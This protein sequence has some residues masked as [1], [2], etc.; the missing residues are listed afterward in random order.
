MHALFQQIPWR[1]SECHKGLSKKLQV[2]KGED[3][4]KYKADY[5]KYEMV[6]INSEKQNY[7]IKREMVW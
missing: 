4:S 5:E 7:V 6:S 3:R 2:G 1:A